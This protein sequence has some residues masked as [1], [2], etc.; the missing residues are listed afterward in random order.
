M[1]EHGGEM[2]EK[3]LAHLGGGV[4]NRGWTVGI[5]RILGS[6]RE[7]CHCDVALAAYQITITSHP[8]ENYERMTHRYEMCESCAKL[9]L[10]SRDARIAFRGRANW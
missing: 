5:Y 3:N 10:D 4:D 7:L 2:E 8:D 1:S 6:E 9:Y